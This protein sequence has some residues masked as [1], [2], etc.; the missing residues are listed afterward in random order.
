MKPI[1]QKSI[2]DIGPSR[3][4]GLFLSAVHLIA[5]IV[6]VYVSLQHPLCLALI[7]PLL[8]SW[9]RGWT[10]Y[11]TQTGR[12]AVTRVE[13][14]TNDTWTLIDKQGGRIKQRLMQRN[15]VAP[16]MTL[17]SFSCHTGFH[18]HVILLG[19]NADA[20][21][22]RRLR[23]RLRLNRSDSYSPSADSASKLSGSSTLGR[24]WKRSS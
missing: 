9:I 18:R 20:D 16:W 13:W 12:S 5:S 1:G 15:F 4:L 11:V 3:S 6:V 23:V 22:V 8:W 21:Q 19:D 2:V 7:L 24:F 17:L 10:I 14:G